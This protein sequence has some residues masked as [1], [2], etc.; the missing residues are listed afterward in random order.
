ML[1]CPDC[2][3]P[4]REAANFCRRCGRLLVDHCPRCQTSVLPDSDFCDHCG[5]ALSPAA[6]L[7]WAQAGSDRS[8]SKTPPQ[9]QH[10]SLASQSEAPSPFPQESLVLATGPSPGPES[11]LDQYIPKELRDKLET[12]RVQGGM[13]GERRVVTMLF[14]D[15]KGSTAAAEQLDPEEWTEIINGAFEHMIRPV[16]KYEGTVARLMGDGILAF[17]GAPIAHE[18]DPQRAVLAGLDIV[19]GIHSYRE[20]V[21]QRYDIDLD[22]RVGINTGMVVVGAVGSDLRMEYT[23]MGDAINLAARMEQTALPGTVQIAQPTYKVV[24]PLFEV[25]ALGGITVKGKEEPVPA[26]RVLGRKDQARQ[27]RGIEGR[28]SPLVGRDLELK[29]LQETFA[30]AL[31]G[32]GRIVCVIGE[33][34]LGKSRLINEAKK[35]LSTGR[36]LDWLETGSLSYETAQPYAL[37]Q[38]L[39]RRLNDIKSSD[40]SELTREKLAGQM[41]ALD[42]AFHQR[43]LRVFEALFN[44][45]SDVGESRLEGEAFK[46]ELYEV[47]PALWRQR[48]ATQPAV[49][50]FEDIH[51]SDPASIDLLLHLFPLTAEIPLV[52][53]CV[54]RPER[55]GAVWR[56]K[57]T[58][59]AD[60]HHRY[61]EINV[62]P[63]SNGQVNEMVDHLLAIADLPGDL[64][65][66]ILE[67]ASGNPFF[68]EEVVRS[69]IDSGAVV[70]KEQMADGQLLTIWQASGDARQIDIPDNLQSLLA[71]RIDRLEEDTRLILQIAAVIGRTF[72]R[73]VLEAL[74]G[75][76]DGTGIQIERQLNLLLRLEMIREATR[77]PELEYKFS[78]PLTQEVAYQTILHRR[79][80]ELHCRVGQ[81]IE[82][83]F[84]GQLTELA[85]RL[86]Y[87]FSEG[88]MPEK[89][90]EY[91]MLAGETAARLYANVEAVGHYGRALA[92]LDEV[93]A[94][95]EQLTAL[96]I[97]HGRALELLSLYPEA[98]ENYEAMLTTAREKGDRLLEF[99]ALVAQATI[100]ATPNQV[101]DAEIGDRLNQ[102]ALE[103]A[104][105]L[106]QK[107]ME[108]KILWNL[109][110]R[111]LWGEFNHAGAVEYGEA[112]MKVAR[113]AGLT[114][115]L[116]KILNDLGSA[117]LG[118]GE[119]ERALQMMEEARTFLEQEQNLPLLALNFT[120]SAMVHFFAGDSE[121][122]LRLLEESQ[123]IDKPI[124]NLWGLAG[125]EYNLAY[126]HV[127][128][129]SWREASVRVD[130]AVALSQATHI[131]G[132]IITSHMTKAVFYAYIGQIEAG[133]DLIE[134]AISKIQALWNIM[135]W[136]PWSLIGRFHLLAGDLT[137]AR[138]MIE[139][140]VPIMRI[141]LAPTPVFGPIEARLSFAQFYL[142]AGE[143]DKALETAEELLSYLARFRVRPFRPDA[144]H[145]KGLALL[146][147][148]RLEE[149][150][151]I[152]AEA[153]SEAEELG[154]RPILWRILAALAETE[155]QL[156]DENQVTSL[157][158]QAWEVITVLANSILDDDHRATFL[159]LQ[160]VQRL[161]R[162]REK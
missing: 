111:Q 55:Q 36:E 5:L 8:Q 108:A 65:E 9:T 29:T 62:R 124:D 114:A 74:D 58:A 14:C 153:R 38:R 104:R 45:E 140:S 10:L 33:A 3:T 86:A 54:F 116:G 117:Y 156:G 6:A 85:P 91:T 12:A 115:E 109:M 133:L 122:A 82:A 16:Y 119:P 137:S 51:W 48:F 89:A 32:I 44:L 76:G 120:N 77:L 67:R 142:A 118:I 83:L 41:S 11:H 150:R 90:F 123:Q 23:A 61:S 126:I 52:I 151:A 73:R 125:S 128:C 47:M 27:L 46:R 59:D 154:C 136:W 60:Y 13:A 81:A 84:P 21:I 42:E 39:I 158:H 159:A 22:V 2:Q 112:A 71:A 143:P 88:K 98:L 79:R 30:A 25:E 20:S 50:V 102:E 100:R 87:H 66:R 31:Q 94:S 63:L 107:P 134:H 162:V 113:K 97:R 135:D 132:M 92:L 28:R 131:E 145:L 26:Y 106:N 127:L 148:D 101:F 72:Y 160:D 99:D 68:V 75:S 69:L 4:N 37:F 35:S 15:V 1:I 17:F 57:T 141:D 95:H 43:A 80:R 110:L 103:L 146:A 144:L 152:L 18:D 93:D 130:K 49:L 78:N 7:G 138:E 105:E 147:Q 40:P 155:E 96:Y 70:A 53:L 24:G 139:K 34:G 129:G 161:E 19:S 64:R 121:T 56:I 157:R 149:A